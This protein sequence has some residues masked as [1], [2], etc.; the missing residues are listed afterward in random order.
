MIKYIRL[1][2]LIL[3][4]LV[5]TSNLCVISSLRIYS[6]GR[7]KV[8]LIGE[9]HN[10]NYRS[11]SC[12]QCTEERDKAH[13]L[14][15]AQ[16]SFN[17]RKSVTF[18]IEETDYKVDRLNKF[19]SQ[20]SFCLASTMLSLAYFSQNHN[21]TAG[22]ATFR[23][24]DN[25]GPALWRCGS[26]MVGWTYLLETTMI[27]HWDAAIRK[28]PLNAELDY[29]G[30]QLTCQFVDEKLSKN[31]SLRENLFSPS[32]SFTDYF[33]EKKEQTLYDKVYTV[34]ALFHELNNALTELS[35][36]SN[37]LDKNS[38]L[39]RYINEYKEL[40]RCAIEDA[41]KFFMESTGN[42]PKTL[43]KRIAQC[44]Y[45]VIVNRSFSYLADEFEKWEI[46]F[47]RI[48]DMGFALVIDEALLHSDVVIL[49]AGEN[50]VDKLE[51]FMEL[52][53]FAKTYYKK[54]EREIR[55]DYAVSLCPDEEMKK[56]FEEVKRELD[57]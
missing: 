31:P 37:A 42:D 4:S 51:P 46:Q 43:E 50:H 12:C 32:S 36:K 13:M 45:D 30:E 10:T 27:S 9:T 3:G 19:L 34:G 55:D 15:L 39:Y 28:L 47:M 56:Y 23:L 22:N 57:L 38:A 21:G 14:D 6:D 17:S 35:T 8:C 41:R 29:R 52:K 2:F 11:G 7:K 16:S 18:C 44:I 5:T 1:G 48:A 54:I 26:C 20:H 49:Y 53:Q 24:A 25:R 33:S 40:L